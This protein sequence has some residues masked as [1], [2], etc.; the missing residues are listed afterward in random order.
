[1]DYNANIRIYSE[2]HSENWRT[3]VWWNVEMVSNDFCQFWQSLTLMLDTKYIRKVGA[4]CY[5][6]SLRY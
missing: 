4:A 6:A 3:K 2:K 5:D 1:M